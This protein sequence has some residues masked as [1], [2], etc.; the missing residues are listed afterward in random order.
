MAEVRSD[1]AQRDFDTHTKKKHTKKD[2]VTR[3]VLR[4]KTDYL[5]AQVAESQTRKQL[6][7]VTN[8]LLGKCK[9]SPLLTNIPAAQLSHSS[10]SFFTE[11][12]KQIGQNLDN[13]PSPHIPA[14]DLHLPALT[15]II[16]RLLLSGEVPSE[17]KTTVVELI[18][19]KASLDP[20]Q[21]KTIAPSRIFLFFFYQ[22]S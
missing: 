13:T 7:S 15:N 3:L 1:S 16:N 21:M 11:K 4:A 2:A 22:R 8:S 9:V 17:F 20:N 10:L 6:F 19:E 18:L 12:I 14:V 5:N